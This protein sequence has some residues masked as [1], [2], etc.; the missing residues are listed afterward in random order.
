MTKKRLLAR[1]RV[2]MMEGIFSLIFIMSLI[3][4][5]LMTITQAVSVNLE[6][7]LFDRRIVTPPTSR[8]IFYVKLFST[9]IY[10]LIHV[11]NAN[12]I[13]AGNEALC[14]EEVDIIPIEKIWTEKASFENKMVV[15]HGEY[16]GWRDYIPN[17]FITRSDWV[18]RDNSGAIYVTG[19]C[20]ETLDPVRDIG[21]KIVVKGVV[22][23]S[24]DGVPY[25]KAKEVIV[26]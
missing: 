13:L 2:K 22:K 12:F 11:N 21:T 24:K 10:N 3:V 14:S 25:I 8:G 17:P 19:K 9:I 1:M 23:L 7:E 15:I 4:M 6:I 20:P 16:M 18:I 5:T 26:K